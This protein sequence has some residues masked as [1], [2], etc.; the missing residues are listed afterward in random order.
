MN[1]KKYKVSIVVA[2]YNAEK[3][4]HRCIDSL[5][6]QTYNNIE[7]ILVDD[8]SIDD[9]SLICDNY[10]MKDNRIKVIHK[11]NGGVSTARQAGLDAATGDYIIHTDP[12]D[13]VNPDMIECLL[14]KII[15]TNSDIVFCDFYLNDNY[16]SLGYKEG[17]DFLKLLVD[18]SVVCS[19]WNALIRKQFIDNNNIRFSPDWLC[20]SEDYLF[21]IRCLHACATYTYLPKAFYHYHNEKKGGLS[22]SKSEKALKSRCCVIDELK[23]ILNPNDY[24]DFYRRKRNVL[25]NCLSLKKFKL[26]RNLY[27]EIHQHVLR[28]GSND[29]V[30]YWLS[31]ALLR[32]PRY[33]YYKMK[34][35]Y[36]ISRIFKK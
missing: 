22:N 10:K 35:Y 15:E 8:G 1:N 20:L 32:S 30:S 31:M 9:S 12:D 17:D 18:V 27:P 7:I 2:V 36:Y 3:H 33:V 29:S 13:Y 34:L 24:N 28:D 14:S 19:C 26:L 6:R 25:I 11:A 4:I 23:K 16:Y 5:L 21:L